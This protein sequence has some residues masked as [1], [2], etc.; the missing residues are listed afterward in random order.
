MKHKKWKRLSREIVYDSFLTVARDK[1]LLPNGKKIFYDNLVQGGCSAVLIK[2]KNKFVFL[3]Q[4]RYVTDE[5]SLEIPMGGINTNESPLECAKRE[6]VEE[7]GLSITNIVELGTTI[8]SN[9]QSPQRMYLYFAE[10]DSSGEPAPDESEFLEVLY[11]DSDL[12]KTYAV[13]GTISDSA[14]QIAIFL[15]EAKNLI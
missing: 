2:H 6:V 8:P 3:R 15:S 5:I 4:Y 10:V 9:G 7:T 1:V 13:D 12:I 11:L 14:T